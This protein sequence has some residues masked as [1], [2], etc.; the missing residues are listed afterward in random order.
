MSR[1][2]VFR[3]ALSRRPVVTQ[4]LVQAALG[5]LMAFGV[6]LSPERVAS[7]MTLTATL[8]AWLTDGVVVDGAVV[9]AKRM[10]ASIAPER[11]ET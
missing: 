8:V 6:K 9:S 11:P 2:S 4:A 10:P 7:L 1:W 3:N 5:T